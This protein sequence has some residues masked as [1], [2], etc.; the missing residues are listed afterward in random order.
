M[1]VKIKKWGING[2]GIGYIRK[3][4]VFVQD[5]IPTELVDIDINKESDHYFVGK[6]KEVIEP[7][8]R[9]RYPL[10]KYWESCGGCTSMH[11]QYKEQAK[12]KQ[13]LLK[14]A[15]KKYANYTDLIQ[16]IIKNPNPLGYRN[17]CKLPLQKVD[18][19]WVAGL[20]QSDSHT[21]IPIERCY[22][23]SKVLEQTRQE[24]IR[25]LNEWDLEDCYSLVMKE[26]DG[27]VQVILVTGNIDIP[28]EL[29]QAWMDI[30]E[31]VSVVQSIKTTADHELFGKEMKVLSGQETM[32][33]EINGLTLELLPESFFQLNTQ[34]AK[35]LYTFVANQI[36]PVDTLVEAYCGVGAIG[37]SVA[38]KAKKVIGI[39][40]NE[41]A[42]LNA[43]DNAKNNE[44][45]NAEFIAGDAGQVFG[46]LKENVDTLIVDPPRSG[47]DTV[48]IDAILLK[49]PKNIVYVSCNPS[50]LAKNFSVLQKKYS[51]ECIQPFDMFSQT[52]HVETVVMMSRDGSRQ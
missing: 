20:Y 23:H 5:T 30:S 45:T 25:L 44:I 51:I 40:Y 39:E 12:M 32:Q 24:V 41:Q 14:Q 50:T 49:E 48:M 42:I 9:R 29:V 8:T 31:V 17:S 6:C 37:L 21:F 26:F 35:Q 52:A 18:G 7:S 47:L 22:I 10:C 1:K 34:Q 43:S 4:P 3:K 11:V 33:L 2:E 13:Q 15:L 38:S 46:Q 27:K 19:K 28:K 36:Q 16:P